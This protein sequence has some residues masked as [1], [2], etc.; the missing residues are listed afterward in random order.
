MFIPY[1]FVRRT[2]GLAS[3]PFLW[4]F[5]RER[6]HLRCGSI[7]R[8]VSYVTAHE[9]CFACEGASVPCFGQRRRTSP[10]RCRIRHQCGTASAETRFSYVLR[11]HAKACVHFV[12]TVPRSSGA[13][14]SPAGHWAKLV[15][16][17]VTRARR[18]ERALLELSDTD[19]AEGHGRLGRPCPS[20]RLRR[21]KTPERRRSL[22]P[23]LGRA[24]SGRR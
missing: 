1:A 12:P 15:A 4:S 20:T 14:R 10:A 8:H 3:F 23:R 9:L 13:P 7:A 24:G 11:T 6:W 19:S 21:N 17:S 18:G 16:R 5:L 22:P 2:V